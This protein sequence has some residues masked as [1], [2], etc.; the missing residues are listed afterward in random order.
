MQLVD[1]LNG[2]D[3][4]CSYG[5]TLMIGADR[6]LRLRFNGACHKYQTTGDKDDNKGTLHRFG[7]SEDFDTKVTSHIPFAHIPNSPR[8]P[9]LKLVCK[10]A[11]AIIV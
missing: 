11:R 9:I 10:F 5:K 8:L 7:I 1:Q 2:A 3:I 4:R 6:W